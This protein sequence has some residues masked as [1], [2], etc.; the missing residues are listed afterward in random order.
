MNGLKNFFYRNNDIIIVL[1]ILTAA[2]YLIY[3]RVNIIMDYPQQA[4]AQNQV[5]TVQETDAPDSTTGTNEGGQ[6]WHW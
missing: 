5:R 3:D 2:A 4:A 6:L 1:L